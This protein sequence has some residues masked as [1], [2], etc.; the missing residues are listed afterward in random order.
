MPATCI[1]R[2][3]ARPP[4]SADL[5]ALLGYL[6]SQGIKL[7]DATSLGLPGYVRLSAQPPAA[8]EALRAALAQASGPGRA[9]AFKETQV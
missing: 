4:A 2:G 1:A 5:P 9:Q 6:R 3:W 8:Q 7:R